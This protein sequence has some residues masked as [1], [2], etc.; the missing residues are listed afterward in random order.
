MCRMRG[1]TLTLAALMVGCAGEELDKKVLLIGLDGVRVDILAA[2]STPHLDALMSQGTFSDRARTGDPTVSGPGWSSMLTGVWPA[3]HGVLGND[4]AGNRYERYPDFLTRLEQLD[5]AY[6][7]FAVVD[8]PPLGTTASNGP[9]LSGALDRLVVIDGDSLG[10]RMADSLSALEATGY[11]RTADPDAAFVYLGDIDVVGHD[12]G[13]LSEAY[14]EAIERADR[15][16]GILVAALAERPRYDREDWLILVSTD[17]GRTDAGGHGGTSHAERTIFY[18]ASG[19]SAATGVPPTAPRIVDVAA[20]ALTHLDVTIDPAWELDGIA[21][22][23][24]RPE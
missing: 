9:L 6:E 24:R 11:L 16:V 22:G 4:F 5:P 19:P 15:Q 23:L 12:T 10:Y 8:W 7:T 14:R 13:S 20:T 3:K 17:H 1:T 21:V 18:L 2:A